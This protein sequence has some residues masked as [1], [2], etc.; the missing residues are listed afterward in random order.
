MGLNQ[1]V[2]SIIVNILPVVVIG[3]MTSFLT[4]FLKYN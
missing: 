3:S 4:R 2:A 1:A